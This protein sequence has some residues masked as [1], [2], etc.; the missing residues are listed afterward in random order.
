M[1]GQVSDLNLN[2]RS[3]LDKYFTKLLKDTKNKEY[4]DKIYYE[5]ARLNYRQQRY[6][7]ALA[8]LRKSVQATEQNKA[9]KAYTYLLAGRI[10]Y[11]NLQRYPLAAAYYDSTVQN[12]PA[13]CPST[14]PLPSG[15]AS[16]SSL[17]SSSRPSRLRTACSPGPPRPDYPDG[18]ADRLRRSRVGRPPPRRRGGRAA[19]RPAGPR[20]KPAAN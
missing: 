8:L 5:M 7:E 17:P 14:R 16:C 15:A 9:Q 12:M 18:Q 13:R 20:R 4:R 6:P 3:R 10:Y 2:D 11:D 1:L 19:G